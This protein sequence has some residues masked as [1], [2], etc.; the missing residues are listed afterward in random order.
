ME[1]EVKAEKKV[2]IMQCRLVTGDN[3]IS[4]VLNPPRNIN[5]IS[6]PLAQSFTFEDPFAFIVMRVPPV[7]HV[8]DCVIAIKAAHLEA[9]QDQANKIQ[10]DLA[11]LLGTTPG[12]V[13]F[14]SPK[15][16]VEGQPAPWN[17]VF[18]VRSKAKAMKF[19][20]MIRKY[21]D[22]HKNLELTTLKSDPLTS[23]EMLEYGPAPDQ[24]RDDQAEYKVVM[25]PLSP[26]GVQG[27]RVLIQ[28][29]Q[30][31][32]WVMDMNTSILNQYINIIKSLG[33][34]Q[35]AQAKKE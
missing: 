12:V 32:Y 11:A 14:T 4:K 23:Q 30:I 6:G 24:E 34:K 3:V 22:E 31:A 29:M 33:R 5:E 20:A 13:G 25:E 21:V 15:A 2:T 7:P 27:T 35:D 17:V 9:L 10:E 8:V 28:S 18:S 16:F 26:L 1:Q 19:E